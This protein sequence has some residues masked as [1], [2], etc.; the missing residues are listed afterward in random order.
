MA[1]VGSAVMGPYCL[2]STAVEVKTHHRRGTH[3]P[4]KRM[5]A[6]ASRPGRTGVLG[7]DLL[8]RLLR[9]VLRG[10]R[11]LLA[12]LLRG[13]LR[14]LGRLLG[15]LLGGLLAVLDGGLR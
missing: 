5:R 10:L 2:A 15:D 6:P 3:R 9:V 8:A 7:A 12:V 14:G 4:L 1:R 13:L 11:D